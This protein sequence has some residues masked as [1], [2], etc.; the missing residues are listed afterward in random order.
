MVV[1]VYYRT[2]MTTFLSSVLLLQP[3]GVR[4]SRALN[5]AAA[6]AELMHINID[7]IPSAVADGLS[8][9]LYAM[10][11]A[12]IVDRSLGFG[13]RWDPQHV[14]VPRQPRAHGVRE[15]LAN[16]TLLPTTF[17]LS[18]TIFLATDPHQPQSQPCHVVLPPRLYSDLRVAN[19]STSSC[20]VWPGVGK[21]R[22]NTG[23]WSTALFSVSTGTNRYDDRT[24]CLLMEKFL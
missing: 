15:S 22:H 16:T 11:R 18:T 12:N 13:I 9:R 14:S 20:V 5:W 1:G 7:C 21:A 24:D 23:P 10:V 4:L 17:V 19:P 6:G 8:G 3:A 2:T